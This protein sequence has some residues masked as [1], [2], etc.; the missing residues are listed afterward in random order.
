MVFEWA[1]DHAVSS[2]LWVC[3]HDASGWNGH[4]CMRRGANG[5]AIPER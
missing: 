5:Q 4:N 3:Q 2:L 1:R